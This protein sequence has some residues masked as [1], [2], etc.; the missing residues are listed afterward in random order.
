MFEEFGPKIIK[1]AGHISQK[2]ISP[3]P[4]VVSK[5]NEGRWVVRDGNK[6]ITALKVLNNPAEAPYKF[7]G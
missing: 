1:L 2:G 6:R 7:H 3:M 5:D 4:I